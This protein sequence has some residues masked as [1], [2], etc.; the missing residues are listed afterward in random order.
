MLI[1]H[2]G[3]HVLGMADY[4]PNHEPI[5]YGWKKGSRHKWHGGRKQK[6]VFLSVDRARLSSWRMAAGEL[7]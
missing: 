4:Q 3:Q 2:K 1:W 6:T 5:M 7:Q